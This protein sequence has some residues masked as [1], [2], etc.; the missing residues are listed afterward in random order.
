M[1]VRGWVAWVVVPLVLVLTG[2][3]ERGEAPAGAAKAPEAKAPPPMEVERVAAVR[4]TLSLRQEVPGRLQAVRTAEIRARVE[5]I[6]EQR[7][8][9]EGSEVSVGAPLYRLDAR[10]LE[11]R[12]KSA[13]AALDKA[14]AERLLAKQ[15]AER[16]KG[17][18]ESDAVSRQEYDQAEAQLKKSGAETLAAEA[19]LTRA[20]IDLEYASIAAPIAGRVGRTRVTEG[21]LVGKGEATHLTTVEQLDPIW[22]NFTQSGPDL[23]RMR[24]AIRQGGAKPI[25]EVEVQLILE[26]DVEY[27]LPGKLQF[28]DMAVDPQ[29]GSVALRAEFPN[30]DRILLPGQFVRVRLAMVT[31]EGIAIPQR[32]VQT[33]PQGQIVLMVDENNKVVPRPIKTGGFSGQ[34]WI[35]LEGL[36][37]GEKVIGNGAQKVRPGAVV[38]PKDAETPAAA[39]GGPGVPGA[40]GSTAPKPAS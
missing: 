28:T 16:L 12:V 26:D 25:E 33:S 14:A 2:G 34:D 39:P 18:V 9:S 23:F 24:R 6:V 11:A 7:L 1:N 31:S 32:T 22:V 35:V 29:T 10:A 19:E 21:A 4:K 13:R 40:S 36:K 5:G 15:T 20:R 3:C 17:L 30:P 38:T 8:F 27:T 37:E